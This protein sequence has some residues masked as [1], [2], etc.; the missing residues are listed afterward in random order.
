[1]TNET[2]LLDRPIAVTGPRFRVGIGDL[3][4]WVAGLGVLAAL[5]RGVR[6]WEWFTPLVDID[7]LMGLSG[8]SLAVFLGLAL[9][10]QTKGRGLSR[11]SVAWRLS[12]SAVLG[13][14]AFAEG[15]I[16]TANHSGSAA[17]SQ[18]ALVPIE[19]TLLMVGTVAALSPGRGL[20]KRR[21]TQ[22]VLLAAAAAVVIAATV[23]FIP[24]LVLLAMD[25]VRN[26]LT[27]PY[28]S[29]WPRVAF[30]EKMVTAGFESLLPLT[31]CLV[32]ALVVSR[33]FRRQG[34]LVSGSDRH[35]RGTLT[36]LS[37]TAAAA[38]GMAWLLA[39][40]IPAL[41][42][43]LAEGVWMTIR[44][45]DAL[46]VVVGF[47]GLAC[48]L[49][50]RSADRPGGPEPG[51][52]GARSRWPVLVGMATACFALLLTDVIVS[53]C[54]STFGLDGREGGPWTRW[55]GWTEAAYEWFRSVVPSPV[56]QVWR[57]S[58]SPECAV[59]ILGQSWV[60]W[61]VAFSLLAPSGPPP[62][63]APID[64]Q[65]RDRE[66][67]GRFAARWAA[68]TVLMTASLPVLFVSGVALL[69]L[70]FRALG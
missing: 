36:L 70:V 23:A 21:A 48:G 64:M 59:L 62:V 10:R 57:S 51:I 61:R 35:R 29:S 68:L 27:F 15:T 24:Y 54:L 9:A 1:M 33:E 65:F 18:R 69:H 2:S 50:A 47:A 56:E 63:P 7:R 41:S 67:F 25:A 19:M 37:A 3:I 28:R 60:A 20:P 26:A 43:W 45:H 30:H 66:S 11:A 32:L 5:T 4:L 44:P 52:V 17:M 49:A 8:L 13:A 46:A 12:M 40:T 39:F 55:V 53:Q 22:S 16:L 6:A 42:G 34:S 38:G 14:F 31:A 58:Q